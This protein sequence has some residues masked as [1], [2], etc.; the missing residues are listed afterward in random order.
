MSGT[1]AFV[2]CVCV[3]VHVVIVS[4]GWVLSELEAT[5]VCSN[6]LSSRPYNHEHTPR[7]ALVQMRVQ[8]WSVGDYVEVRFS[9][10]LGHTF[11]PFQ[12]LPCN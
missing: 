6:H 11:I 7:R 3:C 5:I 8:V 10:G 1:G 2:L 12:T 4:M 9:T